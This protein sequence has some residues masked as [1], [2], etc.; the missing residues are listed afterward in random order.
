[1]TGPYL[2]VTD[3]SGQTVVLVRDKITRLVSSG[4]T[5]TEIHLVDGSFVRVPQP[6]DDMATQLWSQQGADIRS[7][8][9][10]GENS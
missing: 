7:G 2:R 6:V 10:S 5:H 3:S 1:M 4:G 9:S 8:S